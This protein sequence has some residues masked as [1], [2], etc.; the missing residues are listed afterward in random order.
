[1]GLILAMPEGTEG[2]IK[3]L[4]DLNKPFVIIDRKFYEYPEAPTILLNNRNASRSNVDH[5]YKNGFKKLGLVTI[6]R[7]L[8]SL[9]ERKEG[10][11]EASEQL[12]K[13]KPLV[14][15]LEEEQMDAQMDDVIHRALNVDK[16]DGL[17]FFT[18]KVAMTG[19]SLI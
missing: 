15:E 11:I 1:D 14:Y 4:K 9:Q 7:N 3:M 19:L 8:V 12:L 18:N 2:T 10:F 16:V 6:S 17:C 13:S 5:L